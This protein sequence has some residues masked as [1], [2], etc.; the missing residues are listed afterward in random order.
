MIFEPTTTRKKL[1]KLHGCLNYVADIEPFGRP[2]LSH[3]TNAMNG[4]KPNEEVILSTEA[5]MG[6]KV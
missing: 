4:V 5:K 2:F 6:L 1:E 3:L